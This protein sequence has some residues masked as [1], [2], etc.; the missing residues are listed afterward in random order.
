MEFPGAARGLRPPRGVPLEPGPCS[1]GEEAPERPA[2]QVRPEAPKALRMSALSRK[3][4]TFKLRALHSQKK[5]GVAGRSCQEVLRKG[6]LL[7]QVPPGSRDRV[8]GPGR[9][10]C[11]ST[12]GP[13]PPTR[14]AERAC[15]EAPGGLGQC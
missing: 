2:K 5:F 13:G 11:A 15:T 3:P 9:G 14:A 8:G 10:R 1:R 12:C 6:C 7:L 4:K